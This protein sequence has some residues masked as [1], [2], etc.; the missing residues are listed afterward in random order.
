[1]ALRNAYDALSDDELVQAVLSREPAAWPSFFAKFERL[2]A[3]CIRKVML[4]YGAHF[5]EEDLEDL[6]SATALNI[7]KDDYKKLRAF[8]ASRGYRLS[9]WVGLIATNTAH[10]AL[11]RRAPTEV[12]SA[13]AL[14]DTA[15]L[16][17]E[18]DAALAS[19]VLEADDQLRELRGAIAQLSPSDQLFVDYYY[20]QEL[21]PEVI[22]RLMSISV[23]TVYSRKNKVREKLRLIVAR[24]LS[25]NGRT[26]KGD[27]PHA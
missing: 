3:S 5:N 24:T 17:L 25:T 10:D 1:V 27:A 11:R 21:E 23:N 20:V 15:P 4:R 22:A 6:V 19:E 18:S 7:L 2:V 14:D 9:S 13:V 16:K 26:R 12:W 8:D